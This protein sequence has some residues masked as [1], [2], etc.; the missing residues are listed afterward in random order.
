MHRATLLGLAIGWAGLVAADAPADSDTPTVSGV[1]LHAIDLDRSRTRWAMSPYPHLLQT[2]WGQWMQEQIA[3][4]IAAEWSVDAEIV[5]AAAS[6][7][8]QISAGLV[9]DP[10]DTQAPP[11]VV[12][13]GV[14]RLD[15]VLPLLGNNAI[16][17]GMAPTPVW[18]TPGGDLFARPQGWL[19][20]QTRL[21]Q[22]FT[23]VPSVPTAP[24]A[25]EDAA[26]LVLAIEPGFLDDFNR[27]LDEDDGG[28]AEPT[29]QRITLTL[30]AIGV[31]EL[32]LQQLSP[33]RAQRLRAQPPPPAPRA[34]LLA[35]PDDTLWAFSLGWDAAALWV[36]AGA[37]VD[38]DKV[39]VLERAI[40]PL[41]IGSLADLCHDLR[42][43]VQLWCRAA[44][45]FPTLW[46]DAGCTQARARLVL[47][48]LRDHAG[49]TVTDDL[50]GSGA[51]GPLMVQ[52]AWQ[53]GRFR[54]TTDPFGFTASAPTARFGDVPAIQTASAH[55][56][57][58]AFLIAASHS[59]A[60]WRAFGSLL[61]FTLLAQGHQAFATIA[62]D[63][64]RAGRYGYASA[65]V[66]A[67]GHVRFAA[68]G[69]LGGPIG[70]VLT[71]V[72][73]ALVYYQLQM[74]ELAKPI[75][76]PE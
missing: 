12:V 2:P 28:G 72:G 47:G 22:P 16:A 63:L 52:V 56:H 9:R 51:A 14:G 33:E 75:L 70:W 45:P 68:G 26:D 31:H 69:L 76:L 64:T 7:Q 11:L 6:S 44:A 5:A 32:Q 62:T 38:A 50:T 18:L 48:A 21:A 40:A 10:D 54:A 17:A 39:A 36:W 73:G 24:I 60:S 41:G 13:G 65:D 35:L 49:F 8:Q 61:Q 55:W 66:T 29:G 1:A 53:D 23:S 37:E 43:D 67:D 74:A 25:S 58:D 15:D 20:R 71:G 19:W 57:P 42:D 4:L 3:T 59:D 30:D 27:F 46:L 34:A